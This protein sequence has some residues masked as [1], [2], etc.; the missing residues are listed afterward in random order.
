VSAPS[1][2]SQAT[3]TSAP[4]GRFARLYGARP[5]HLLSLLA[6]FALT[7]YVVRRLLDETSAFVQIAVWFIGGAV[8]WDLVLG[9]ALA[10][11]D[12]LVRP[13]LGAVQVRGVSPLNHLRVPALVSSLLLLLFAP[14]VLQR[15]KQ[16]Y[17]AKTGLLQ[18]PYL[19]RWA[20][21]ALSLFT[22]SALVYAVAVLRTH[23]PPARGRQA[24]RDGASDR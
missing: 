21:V 6:S 24:G 13:R 18:D 16:T 23:R 2:R 19:E 20:A 10:L 7:G 22:L 14:L 3:T 11:A 9:P 4:A 17:Q 8:V 15:S 1:H 12:R 5:W